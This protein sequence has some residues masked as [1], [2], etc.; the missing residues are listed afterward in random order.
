MLKLRA[1]SEP[2]QTVSYFSSTLRHSNHAFT[3][4]PSSDP[5]QITQNTEAYQFLAMGLSAQKNTWH[6][7][8]IHNI[9]DISHL[10]S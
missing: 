7:V 10:I 5:P 8:I 4:E 1:L 6:G 2:I 9:D 3:T